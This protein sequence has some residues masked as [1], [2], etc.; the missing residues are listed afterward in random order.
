MRLARLF[1]GPIMAVAGILHFV[2]PAMY[3]AIMPEWLPAHRELV[4][5]SGVTELAGALGSMH[6]RTRRAAGLLQIATLV[7]VFPAN[8]DMALHPE[9]YGSVPG[10]HATLLARLPLQALFV[11]W[12]WK[13][14]LSPQASER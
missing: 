5:A 6:P 1:A 10:G 14:T 3:E 2:R 11:F 7:G 8:V 9:K 4:Y 12:V 13:A